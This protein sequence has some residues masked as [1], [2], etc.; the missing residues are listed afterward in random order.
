MFDFVFCL[1]MSYSQN[2]LLILLL[3]KTYNLIVRY[4]AIIA[5]VNIEIERISDMTEPSHK[6]TGRDILG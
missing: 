1:A 5:R 6:C 3:L 4:N 2:K